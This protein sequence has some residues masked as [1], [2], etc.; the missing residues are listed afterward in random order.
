M[1]PVTRF[2][3]NYPVATYFVLAF[4]ISWAGVAVVAVPLGITGGTS[5]L[6]AGFLAMA[7]GPTTASLLLTGV[8]EGTDGYRNLLRRLTRWRVEPRW[9]LIL[10][11]NPLLILAVL[12]VSSLASPSFLPGV[13][14]AGDRAELVAVALAGGLAA[15]LFE[16]I[17]WTGFATPRLLARHSFFVA[18]LLLGALWATW[19]IGPGIPVSGAWG[20]MFPW[21]ILTWTY[22]G[23]VP[24]RVL[25]TWVYRHTSSLLLGVLMHATYTG[26]QFLLEPMGASQT[27]NLTW[28]ALLGLG[29]WLVVGIVALARRHELLRRVQ[30]PRV[31]VVGRAG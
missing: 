22:A 2:I 21:Y 15:G 29:L 30:P 26:G 24:F 6:L 4:G 9:Y 18:G 28:W 7:V 8:L 12:G 17:G 14:T 1:A 3:E 23:M 16:E 25:M 31:S 13:L 10:L 27:E 19:H 11:L 5:Y 20:G